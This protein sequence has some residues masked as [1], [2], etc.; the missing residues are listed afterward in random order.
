MAIP[1]FEAIQGQLYINGAFTKGL[2]GQDFPVYNPYDLSVVGYQAVA[3]PQDVDRALDGAVTAFLD[4]KRTTAYERAAL[5][6]KLHGLMVAKESELAQVMTREQGKPI[7][8]ALGEV[9]YAASYVQWYA[10]EGIRVSGDILETHTPGMRLSVLKEPIGPVGIITPWNFP[11]AMFVRKLAPALAA[12]C[13]V[14][15][16]PAEQTPLTAVKFFELLDQVRF[17]PGVCQLVAGDGPQIGRQMMAHK[18]I[19]KVSFTGST[20]VGQILASQSGQTLKKLSLELGGH[21]PLIVFEDANLDKAVLGTLD[22]KFRNCGQVCIATNRVLVQRGVLEAYTEKLLAKVAQLKVGN[23]FES[24]DMGPIIDGDGFNKISDHVGDALERGAMCLC[25]GVGYRQ[26]QQAKEGV[27][28]QGL[29]GTQGVDQSLGGYLFPP[30]VITRV[31]ADMRIAREETF[32]PVVPIM[33]F[34]T[35]E[36]ALKMANDTPYGLSAYAFTENLSRAIR[37][38][39]GLDYGM[40]GINTGRISSA[41]APFGGVKM[42]GYGREGGK[43]GIEDYLQ[44]K[45]V[46]IGL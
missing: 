7:A 19:R 33:V 42:S 13:T 10:E 22:S 44:L 17:P 4:W 40:I 43:Y 23:G 34:D 28:N 24:V 27:G 16:K 35:E 11:L 41:Q 26:G 12:G 3:G 32:G 6:R 25:G 2:L 36:E 1:S 31:T 46:G 15:V 20:E 5:L 8:E 9:R 37:V 14:V 29:T 30:T 21:A 39:E 38:Q 45:Y 18:G